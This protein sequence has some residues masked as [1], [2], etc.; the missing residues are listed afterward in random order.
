MVEY[1]PSPL[2]GVFQAVAD[3]TRRA[4]LQRLGRKSERVTDLAR[5]FP[6][7][8]N[9]VSKHL[10]VLERAGLISREIRGRERVCRLNGRPLRDA[11]LWLAE[12]Q[13]F[14]EQRLDALEKHVLK[15]R[16]RPQ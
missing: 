13:T 12:M 15:R 14:W 9:A 7:S 8:L 16:K 1:R 6:V 2:D 3:P 5:S 10:M 4:I 11:S